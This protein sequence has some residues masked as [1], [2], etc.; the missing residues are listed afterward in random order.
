MSREVGPCELRDP[1]VLHSPSSSSRPH[2]PKELTLFLSSFS[3]CLF[4]AGAEEEERAR[5]MAKLLL[6]A[7]PS[8]FFSGKEGVKEQ[9]GLLLA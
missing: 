4:L 3:S 5:M 1:I 8:T 6:V 2:M 9:G 7:P